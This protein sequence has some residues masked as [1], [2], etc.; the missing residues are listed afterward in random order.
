MRLILSKLHKVFSYF[1]VWADIQF[2]FSL[3][4]CFGIS[5]HHRAFQLK[6]TLL[7]L[8][9]ASS[10]GMYITYVRPREL[11]VSYLDYTF[12]GYELMMMDFFGHHVLLLYFIFVVMR[13]YRHMLRERPSF[14][15]Y[16]CTPPFLYFMSGMPFDEL[17][18]LN[19]VDLFMIIPF[20]FLIY[21]CILT[22]YERMWHEK[23]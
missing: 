11:Y 7:S 6:Q 20:G 1:S 12:K 19:H 15:P 8:C 22:I 16:V 9:I 17:Y 18:G 4:E 13:P 5:V 14:S 3:S 2:L 23:V 10:G 21:R